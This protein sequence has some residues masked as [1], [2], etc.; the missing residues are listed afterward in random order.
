MDLW[1][2][3]MNNYTHIKNKYMKIKCPSWKEKQ[4]IDLIPLG[5]RGRWLEVNV[6][7]S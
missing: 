4:E 5:E 6:D 2:I 3:H 7:Q 1:R